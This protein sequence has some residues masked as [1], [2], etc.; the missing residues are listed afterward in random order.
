MTEAIGGT[1][2]GNYASRT[3]AEF[4]RNTQR[5]AA[6]YWRG[7]IRDQGTFEH[8]FEQAVVAFNTAAM[9]QGFEKAGIKPD[10]LTVLELAAIEG[11]LANQISHIGD[12]ASWLAAGQGQFFN[13]QGPQGGHPRAA[14]EQRARLWCNRWLDAYNEGMQ[15]GAKDGKLKWVMG[16]TEHCSTCL[17]LSNRV[18][19]ASTWARYDI[20]PQHPENLECKGYQCQCFFVPT[21]EPLTP[22]RPPNVP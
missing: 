9:L 13:I 4:C 1:A 8:S 22:G 12:F 17:K 18:Y 14:V 16:P 19:R 10:E 2:Y 5:L 15:I 7:Q 21:N 11:Y 3:Q 6:E 20:H